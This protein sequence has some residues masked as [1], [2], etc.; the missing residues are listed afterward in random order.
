MKGKVELIIILLDFMEKMKKEF[1]DEHFIFIHS[2][3]YCII[4]IF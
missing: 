4:I 3:I 1:N 2:K